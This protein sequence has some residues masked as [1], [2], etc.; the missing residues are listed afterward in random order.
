[1]N[2]NSVEKEWKRAADWIAS[3]Y[4]ELADEFGVNIDYHYTSAVDIDSVRPVL[5]A[6]QHRNQ[7]PSQLKR[8][9][10]VVTIR[11]YGTVRRYCARCDNSFKESDCVLV[12]DDDQLLL[13]KIIH[14]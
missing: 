3:L 4:I 2:P 13:L 6:I 14:P 11:R 8:H 1:M 10:P 9:G 12:D 7:N 5:K